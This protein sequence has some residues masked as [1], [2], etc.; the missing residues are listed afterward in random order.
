M[1]SVWFLFSTQTGETGVSREY[2]TISS[3]SESDKPVRQRRSVKQI[4]GNWPPKSRENW[5]EV[6]VVVD[7]PMV[8]YHGSKVRH[9]VLTLMRMVRRQLHVICSL[10]LVDQGGPDLPRQVSW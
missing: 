3:D 4:G 6:L 7:G 1:T 10:Y 9:Y 2:K 5:L 8:K